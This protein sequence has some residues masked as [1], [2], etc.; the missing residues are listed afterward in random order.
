MEQLICYRDFGLQSTSLNGF[1]FAFYVIVYGL[2]SS[3][4]RHQLK[5][6]DFDEKRNFS[7]RFIKHKSLIFEE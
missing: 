7:Q 3:K 5:M 2:N 6:F 4:L 1:F